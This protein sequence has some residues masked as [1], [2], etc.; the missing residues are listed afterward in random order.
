MTSLIENTTFDEGLILHPPGT[1]GVP[2]SEMARYHQ[3]TYSLARL[4]KPPG[5]ILN[6]ASG[7][8]VAKNCN[9]FVRNLQGDWLWIM[10]DD[11]SFSEDLLFRL[12]CRDVDVIVPLVWKK[13][14]P[15][16]LVSFSEPKQDE[17]TGEWGYTPIDP[18]DLPQTGLMEIYAAGSA[19]MLIRKHVLDAISDPWFETSGEHQNEDLNFCAKIRDAGFKIYLDVEAYLGHVGL[20]EMWPGRVNGVWGALMHFD[21]EH[22][23]FLGADGVGKVVR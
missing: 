10:G 18:V 7:L 19:G 13:R 16:Q 2:V 20:F 23:I 9:S 1:V 4:L 22:K 17:I 8:S 5:T 11:H 12:L 3:F 21:S 6:M 15:F 14:P